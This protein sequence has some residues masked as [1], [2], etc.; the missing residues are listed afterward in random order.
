MDKLRS[1]EVFVRAVDA[2]SFSEAARQLGITPVMVGKH[3]RQL[4]D[5]LRTRLLQR[6]TRRQS[7]TDAG[8]RFYEEG[9]KVLE[10]LDW[11]EASVEQL[12]A[13]PSGRLRISAATTL[14]ECVVAPLAADYQRRHPEVS[15]ELELSNGLADLV[16]EGF[17]LAVRVGGLDSAQ[18]LVAR[19]LGWYRMVI[20]ASPDYLRRHGRPQTLAE[21]AQHRC[22][23]HMA[24]NR[25]TAWHLAGAEGEEVAQ[26]PAEAVFLCNA[27][28]GLRQAALRGAGLLL[29][30]QVLVA[31]D[32]AAGRLASVLEAHVPPAR[33]VHLLYR[34]D[35]RPLPKTSTFVEF[36]LEQA[37]PLLA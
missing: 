27:G 30:P 37:A 19:P 21:L 28:Q 36:L 8:R 20:C 1:I 9:R 16:D 2:G 15:I 32:L 17:D 25:R 4:E 22:L 5:H 33:P 7:L 12:R 10:Q 23:G 24:W 26:W 3:V 34:Q 31:D 6:S 35:R 11:A 13:R 14:G 29:Q 18:A